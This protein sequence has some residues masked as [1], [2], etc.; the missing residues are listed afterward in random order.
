MQASATEEGISPSDIS[1]L[2]VLLDHLWDNVVDTEEAVNSF[3]GDKL[4]DFEHYSRGALEW[5]ISN[6]TQ[7]IKG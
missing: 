1:T 6:F 2:T 4:A 5:A 3:E 7:G